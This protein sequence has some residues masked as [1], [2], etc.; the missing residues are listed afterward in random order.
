MRP[1]GGRRHSI[2]AAGSIR[3]SEYDFFKKLVIQFIARQRGQKTV[4]SKDY[5]FT[6]YPALEKFVLGFLIDE[7]HKRS[8]A[9]H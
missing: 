9:T 3:Y 2:H 5:D 7:V 8:H 6:D 1:C 4:M